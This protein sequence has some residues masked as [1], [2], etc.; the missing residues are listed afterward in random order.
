M[1]NEH[2]VCVCVRMRVYVG[3]GKD[4]FKTVSPSQIRGKHINTLSFHIVYSALQHW[5]I[6]RNNIKL[7]QKVCGVV[8][9]LV[10]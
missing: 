6:Q 2:C 9:F 10:S 5:T 1:L 8:L 4:V 7:I 3:I